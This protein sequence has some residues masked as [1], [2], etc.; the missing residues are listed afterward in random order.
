MRVDDL[1]GLV[2]QHAAQRFL[3]KR[4]M[5]LPMAAAIGFQLPG[6]AERSVDRYHNTEGRLNRASREQL[7]ESVKSA[8]YS[9]PA[10]SVP[11]GSP[12]PANKS[13]GKPFNPKAFSRTLTN[14]VDEAIRAAKRTP[15]SKTPTSKSPFLEGLARLGPGVGLPRSATPGSIALNLGGQAA[16]S[17]L[18]S[19]GASLLQDMYT[20]AKSAISSIGSDSARKAVLEQ[21]KKED[22]ILSTAS[23]AVLMESFHTMTRFAP[24]LSTDKNA[25]R[26]FLRQAVMGGTGPDFT[27][28]KLLAE[29]ERAVTG[30]KD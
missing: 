28:I 10:P 30:K 20:K 16:A 21:L 1:K 25:V 11:Y 5:S 14:K 7:D 12:A 13:A 15:S 4:G 26:S 24:T 3:E 23:D 17:A 9:S 18:G 29:S 22:P 8:A 6:L 19:L 27:T 2:G